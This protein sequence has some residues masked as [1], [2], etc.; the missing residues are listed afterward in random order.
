MGLYR[1]AIGIQP[2]KKTAEFTEKEL[3][4]LGVITFLIGFL[5]GCFFYAA[6][7]AK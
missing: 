1:D 3:C 6:A 5:A 4:W 2:M 7:M